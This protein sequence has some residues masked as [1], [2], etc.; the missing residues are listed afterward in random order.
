[1]GFGQCLAANQWIVIAQASDQKWEA[2]RTGAREEGRDLLLIDANSF[3]KKTKVRIK[4]ELKH[5]NMNIFL[6]H[7][8]IFLRKRAWPGSVLPTPELCTV[9]SS[10][11]LSNF[12]KDNHLKETG[13]PLK[14]KPTKLSIP[15]IAF[16]FQMLWV[17]NEIRCI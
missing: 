5:G 10:Q 14:L 1:M 15:W 11:K 12:G 17:S 13:F 6:W 2:K 4:K 9:F 8:I 16:E 7:C 3:E